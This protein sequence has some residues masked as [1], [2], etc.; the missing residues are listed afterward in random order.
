MLS[1]VTWFSLFF[2]LSPLFLFFSPLF[3]FMNLPHCL[4]FPSAPG[5]NFWQIYL[6]DDKRNAAGRQ[7]CGIFSLAACLP[8]VTTF[9]SKAAGVCLLYKYAPFR[10]LRFVTPLLRTLAHSPNS[11]EIS[12]VV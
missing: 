8:A 1:K 9:F 5:S 11:Q 3:L 10:D 2:C 6:G 7:A 12:N 4:S